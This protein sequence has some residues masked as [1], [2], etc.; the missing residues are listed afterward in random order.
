MKIIENCQVKN[1]KI[2]GQEYFIDFFDGIGAKKG[3]NFD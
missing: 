3:F 2:A 1:L